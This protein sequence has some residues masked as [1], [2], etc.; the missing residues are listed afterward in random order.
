MTISPLLGTVD[1]TAGAVHLERTLPAPVHEV[2]DALT[3]PARLHAWLAPVQQG[4]PGP[5]RTFVL[6]MNDRETATCTVTTW[7]PPHE[8]R[9]M[10]DYT[11]EGPSE[12][13]LRLS[14]LGGGQTRLTLEHTRIPADA[15]QYGAGWH[16]HLDHLCAYLTGGYST[17]GGCDDEGFLAAYRAL[18]PRYAATAID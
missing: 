15:V 17:T 12:L 16:V 4:Q 10:W 9:V 2:W 14:E 3:D 13:S 11:D 6:G 5:E 7:N 18:E 8:L 1:R